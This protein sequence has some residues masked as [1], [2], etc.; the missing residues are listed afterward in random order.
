MLGVQLQVNHPVESSAKTNQAAERSATNKS[1]YR[2]FS[3]K[4]ITLQRDRLQINQPAE[5]SATHKSTC[6]EISYKQ[7]TL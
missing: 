7:I 2:Q 5:R 1:L 4:Q 6:R 3:Y